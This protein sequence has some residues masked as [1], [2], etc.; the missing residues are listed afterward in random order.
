MKRTLLIANIVLAVAVAALYILF[1]T[2]HCNKKVAGFTP[3]E[4]TTDLPAGTI[5]YVQIDSLVNELDLFHALRTEVE[6]KIKVI[7]DDLTRKGRAFER[8]YLDFNEKIQKGLLTRSQAE[9]QG[10][11]LEKRQR[12]L[13]QYSQQKQFE[14][15]EEQ[16]VMLN[17]VLNEIK[18]FL[19]D[20]NQEHNFSLIITTSVATNNVIVGNP[21]LD[22]TKNVIAG[23]NAKYATQ[24]KKK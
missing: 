15:E 13:Q 10:E 6:A 9:T 20:Y 1:F 16:Q 2:G 19:S 18:V 24:V 3:V 4:S 8:D 11:Q 23:L 21:S 5:V 14:L 12:E 17:N 7:D 22:I